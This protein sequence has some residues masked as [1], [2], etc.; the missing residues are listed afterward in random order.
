LDCA[1][2]EVGNGRRAVW[3]F[4]VELG[5]F[6]L[7]FPFNP[8][9]PFA[10]FISET[11]AILWDVF[12]DDFVEQDGNG[13]EVAGEGIGAHAKG[14]ERDGAAAGKGVNDQGACAW[15]AAQ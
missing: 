11:L 13:I 9:A 2:P 6:L 4:W 1:R 8:V 5:Q 14:F 7:G 15:G 10:D 3:V 12:E